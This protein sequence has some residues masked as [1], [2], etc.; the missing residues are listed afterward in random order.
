MSRKLY[1]LFILLGAIGALVLVYLYFFVYYTST[2]TIEANIWEYKVELF[3]K[4]T[5]Q[6]WNY[7]CPDSVCSLTDVSP[8]DYNITLSKEN[9]KTQLLQMKVIARKKQSLFVE[10]EKQASLEVVEVTETAESA[11]QK[12]KR[13]RGKN[14]YYTSF[15]LSDDDKITFTDD[16]ASQI[17][18][19]LRNGDSIR[20]IGKFQKVPTDAIHAEF[21]A[22]TQDV[23]MQLWNTYFIYKNKAGVIHELPYKIAV[24]YVKPAMDSSKYIVVTENGSFLYDIISAQSEFYYLFKDFI[25]LDTDTIIWVIYSDEDQ[26]RKNFDIEEKWN[27]IIRYTSADKQR[28]VLLAGTHNID[29]IIK[30]NDTI[31]FSSDGKQYELKNFE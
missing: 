6:K 13:L 8:F 25:Y 26:K 16:S 1:A 4:S 2:L 24:K 10:F 30:L 19:Q 17:A 18:M 31:L 27:V 29:S 7:D 9:Y 14:L 23:F 22:G 21:I 20:E 15:A 12:I 5:A 3:S 11:Q 28:K